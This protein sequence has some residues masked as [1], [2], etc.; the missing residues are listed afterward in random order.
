MHEENGNNFV[1]IFFFV[2]LFQIAIGAIFLIDN[3]MT[4]AMR[5]GRVRKEYQGKGILRKLNDELIKHYPTIKNSS[6]VTATNLPEVYSKINLGVIK[7]ITIQV[8]S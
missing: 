7:L 2:F 3:G 1:L 4:G 8:I 6:Y 5:N